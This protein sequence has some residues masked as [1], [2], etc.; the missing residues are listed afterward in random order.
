M[1][2]TNSVLVFSTGRHGLLTIGPGGGSG[3]ST[4]NPRAKGHF[5]F[6]KNNIVIRSFLNSSVSALSSGLCEESSM[7]Q[8]WG[9]LIT[10]TNLLPSSSTHQHCDFGR[11]GLMMV[12]QE[13]KATDPGGL[14]I[15]I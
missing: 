6:S 3:S 13:R 2:D 1:T 8:Y 12:P 11:I 4:V 14:Y 15:R 7:R 9:R 5:V 10:S